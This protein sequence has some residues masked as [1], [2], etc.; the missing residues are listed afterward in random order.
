MKVSSGKTAFCNRLAR[1]GIDHSVAAELGARASHTVPFSR[2]DRLEREG[3]LTDSV[4]LLDTGWLANVGVLQDGSAFFREVHLPGDIVGLSN[5]AWELATNDLMALTDGMARRL[6]RSDLHAV[7][8]ASPKIASVLL[9][10]GIV[11]QTALTD[12][13][14]HALKSDGRARL[15][16]FLLDLH[17]RQAAAKRD[18]WVDLPITQ[19]H[20]SNAI[21]LSK[22]HVNVLLRSLE[23]EGAIERRPNAVRL[24]E[25]ATLRDETGYVVRWENI[26]VS[27]ILDMGHKRASYAS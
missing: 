24:N 26:D 23:E 21:G 18:D 1:A 27:W 16:S 3:E 19:I 8:A 25:V 22:V 20:V 12:R 11:Q 7:M 17:D 4:Y 15:L 2:G 9:T 10:F 14:A 13:H 6:S 5:L